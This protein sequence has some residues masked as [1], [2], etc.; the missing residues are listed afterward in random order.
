MLIDTHSH[1]AS[2]VYIG[3][4]DE[5][6]EF[7]NLNGVK[8]IV[9]VGCSTKEIKESLSL[10]QKYPNIY[11]TAGLFPHDTIEDSMIPLA[12]RLAMIRD[13]A[14]NKKIVAVGECGLDFNEPPPWEIKREDKEQIDLF[15][16]QVRIAIETGLPLII[17][18]RNSNREIIDILRNFKGIKAVWHCFT[19][20]IETAQI[21]VS[22]GLKLSFTGIITYP[23]AQ[24]IREAVKVTNIQ[25]IMIETD[26]PYLTPHN[27][28]SKGVKINTPGYVKMVAEKIAEIKQLSIDLVEKQTTENAET[29]FNI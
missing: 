22:L 17:H 5:L 3:K 25:D 10:A 18:S 8:K 24:K 2:E 11:A 12:D 6:L 23:N 28:R 19:E 16:E 7:A 21:A 13:L 1:I 29:F 9:S 4:T 26:S 15:T 14:L 20:D 27:A